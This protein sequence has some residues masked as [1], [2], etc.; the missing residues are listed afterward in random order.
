MNHIDRFVRETAS[1]SVLDVM[2]AD[3]AVRIQLPPSEYQKAVDHYE[4]INSWLD[5]AD[6]P[7]SRRTPCRRP[8]GAGASPVRDAARTRGT[9]RRTGYSRSPPGARPGTL[10]TAP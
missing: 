4:A 2:L 7:S 3:I 10:P 8:H 1:Y 9:G 5:R 6:C